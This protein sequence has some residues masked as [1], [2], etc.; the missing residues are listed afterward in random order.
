MRN[1]KGE[2]WKRFCKFWES[3][4]KREEPS[5]RMEEVQSVTDP[6]E[7]SKLVYFFINEFSVPKL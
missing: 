4:N 2:W 1:G 3:V 6:D 7:K 5:D